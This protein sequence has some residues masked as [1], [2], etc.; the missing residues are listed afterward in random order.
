[1]FGGRGLLVDELMMSPPMFPIYLY[2]ANGQIQLIRK[3]RVQ[4]CDTAAQINELA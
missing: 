2:L 1:M 4:V 3:H